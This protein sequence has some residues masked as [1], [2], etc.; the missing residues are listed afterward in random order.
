MRIIAGDKR[1]CQLVTPKGMDTRPTLDRVKESLF[2]ILQFDIASRRVLDL[3]AGSG[4]LGLECLSRHAEFAVFCDH[5]RESI[6]AVRE[7]I[8]KLGYES[9][10]RVYQ[11]DWAQ[12]ISKMQAAGDRFD[13]VFL[14]PPYK[15]GLVEKAIETLKAH[16]LLNEECIIVAEHD[17]K[18]PPS[19][20]DG[21]EIYDLR[22]YGELA[23][24]SFIRE[25]R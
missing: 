24:I 19:A 20:P 4:G 13:L 2:G 22:K 17:S 15:A 3:F 5:S 23:A 10:S 16:D 18:L 8:K 14:D 11:C 9:R 12:A 7:N 1:G 6:N 21:F 25:A